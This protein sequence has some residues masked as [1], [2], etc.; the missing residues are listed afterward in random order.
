MDVQRELQQNRYATMHRSDI[1]G[2]ASI[3][4]PIRDWT[5]DVKFAISLVGS[6]TILDTEPGTPHVQSLLE[7]TARA[8]RLLGGTPDSAKGK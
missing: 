1:S 6:H 3:A 7:A 4:A 5:G 2:Y 8:T